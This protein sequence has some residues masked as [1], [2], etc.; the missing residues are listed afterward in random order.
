MADVGRLGAELDLC[1]QQQDEVLEAV[2]TLSL[3]IPNLP[4]ESV[5]VG[6]DEADNL[7]VRRWG[8]PREFDFEVKDHV[9]LG[10]GLKGLDF[11][12]ATKLSGSRFVVIV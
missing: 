7:E 1:K 10:E 6:R 8:E 2:R 11:A 9:A 12:T 5:P 4:H 3:H